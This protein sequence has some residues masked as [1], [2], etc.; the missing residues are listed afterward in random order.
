MAISKFTIPFTTADLGVSGISRVDWLIEVNAEAGRIEYPA[1]NFTYYSGARHQ[2]L[3]GAGTLELPTKTGA[4]PGDFEYKLTPIVYGK[5]RVHGGEQRAPYYCPAPSS[6]A[7]ISLGTLADTS[8]V[9]ESWM[10]S[11]TA[12]L[13][14]AG[15]AALSTTVAAKDEAVAAKAAAEAAQA[16]A[17]GL[18]IADLGT[19]DGQTKT[20]IEAGDSQTRTALDA[21]IVDGATPVAVEQA[22]HLIQHGTLAPLGP[23]AWAPAATGIANFKPWSVGSDGRVYG[24]FGGTGFA[25][26]LNA[27]GTA[28]DGTLN[29]GAKSEHP[30]GVVRWITRTP[31]GYTVVVLSG[32]SSSTYIWHSPTWDIAGFTLKA[33]IPKLANMNLGIPNAAYTS[34]GKCYLFLAIWDSG[35]SKKPVYASFDGG[36]TWTQIRESETAV[37]GLVNNHWH[38][39]EWDDVWKRI[40][41]AGGD[42]P[43]SW[44]GYGEIDP[45]TG[46]TVTWTGVPSTTSEPVYDGKDYQQ[47]TAIA[48]FG[49][50]LMLG[51]DRGLLKPGVW[52]AD[53]LTGR[54]V[55]Q[56]VVDGSV[57]GPDKKYPIAPY[58]RSGNVAYFAY[59]ASS[60]MPVGTRN[61]TDIIATGD[62]GRSYHKVSTIPWGGATLDGEGIVGPDANGYLWH[63]TAVL[64]RA[65]VLDWTPA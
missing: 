28:L 49:D 27:D 57:V 47:P 18:V 3:G 51:P 48:A 10:S 14:A 31:A 36:P 58:A 26:R 35:A 52:R 12:L 53:P 23:L 13:Q 40:W 45:L 55:P 46:N 16:A 9:P 41:L 56:A 38:A 44:F 64:N 34:E 60:S 59:P 6:T 65:K 24:R 39:I 11:A 43:N 1:D 25:A 54:T 19:T 4:L 29:F 17:E 15:Q 8:T 32:S 50:R 42:G 33:T 61:H 22:V 63:R 62:G 20:L 37:D 7:A 21:A 2:Y 30:A 5:G